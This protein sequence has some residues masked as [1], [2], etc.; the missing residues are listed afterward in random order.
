MDTL[1]II[2]PI[3]SLGIRKGCN[4]QLLSTVMKLLCI[5]T[6]MNVVQV[7]HVSKVGMRALCGHSS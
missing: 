1:T 6:T 4:F 3:P 2:F 7:A 5:T